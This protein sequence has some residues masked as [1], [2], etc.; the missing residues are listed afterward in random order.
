MHTY[1]IKYHNK[2]KNNPKKEQIELTL[3][4]RG[5]DLICKLNINGIRL[6]SVI[7]Q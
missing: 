7:H 4:I 1:N 5:F 6:A 3:K 2:K